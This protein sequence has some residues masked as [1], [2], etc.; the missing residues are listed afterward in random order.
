MEFNGGMVQIES[1]TKECLL[2]Y[3]KENEESL[4]IENVLSEIPSRSMPNGY[5]VPYK[6]L[7][8]VYSI[9]D[10]KYRNC[11]I[12]VF[13]ID[14]SGSKKKC[15]DYSLAEIYTYIFK[16]REEC[17]QGTIDGAQLA[18]DM[19]R[20]FLQE[21]H[22]HYGLL[23][24]DGTILEN[25]DDWPSYPMQTDGRILWIKDGKEFTPILWFGID[26]QQ[27]IEC[28]TLYDRGNIRDIKVYLCHNGSVK[29]EN[30]KHFWFCDFWSM[31]WNVIWNNDESAIT[32]AF[33]ECGMDE[34][35]DEF[36]NVR[37]DC[38]IELANDDSTDEM[39]N[40]VCAYCYYMQKKYVLEKAIV[41]A[42]YEIGKRFVELNKEG[43]CLEDGRPNPIWLDVEFGDQASESLNGDSQAND[44]EIDEKYFGKDEFEGQYSSGNHWN[45]LER[46]IDNVE[47]LFYKGWH[48]YLIEQ[49]GEDWENN[50]K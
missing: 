32:W 41:K 31:D 13:T 36:Q 43:V 8:E 28:W 23:S 6:K 1:P 46:Y 9:I 25:V 40:K 2:E 26:G 33:C 45:V 3:F 27:P 20:I 44:I 37:N 24:D 50:A 16:Q 30:W 29:Q 47:E 15:C 10:S 35:E 7:D 34:P 22:W 21:G 5:G 14:D 11:K 48:K 38:P 4:E 18:L 49:Y 19:I 42:G 12:E 17:E 39:L